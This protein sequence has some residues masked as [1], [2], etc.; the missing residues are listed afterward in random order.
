MSI[1]FDKIEKNLQKNGYSIVENVLNEEE[2]NQALLY[3][4]EWLNSYE[5]I[6]LTHN[7][8]SPHGIIKFYEIG[9][10]KHAWYIRTRKNILDIYKY[11]WNTEELVVSYDGACW[12]DKQVSKKDTIWTHSDQA[13]NKNNFEC[14]QS[15]VSLTENQERT[16]IVYEGSHLL[17]EKYVKEKNLTHKNNWF[18]IDKE[19][20]E[21]IQNTKKILHVK[22]GT[23]VIWD[24]R[25]FHQNQYGK[26]G[27]ER[28][29][30]YISYL[31][32]NNLTK[33]MKEKRLKYFMERR[34]TTHWAYPVKVIGY[35]PQIY[36]NKALVIDY[37]LL[38]PP[39]LDNLLE[40]IKKLI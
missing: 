9:H 1:D 8:I 25:T 23:L 7:N 29:V 5:Q 34:T 15:F 13:P 22:P 6:K 11:L 12:I 27:E 20:L 2:I 40:D 4:H 24:S 10:Q 21:K 35:Q 30:Q 39:E 31:P 37:S 17:H 36:N 28:I 33:K 38:K 19:Y 14:Y 32:K 3:F 16:F 26:S 18:L